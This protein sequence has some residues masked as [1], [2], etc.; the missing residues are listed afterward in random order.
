MKKPNTPPAPPTITVPAMPGAN[1]YAG[2]FNLSASPA[3]ILLAQVAAP[4]AAANMTDSHAVARAVALLYSCDEYL[5][6][7][8][9]AD[10]D[11]R[12]NQL[13]PRID[14]N[15]AVEILE[16]SRDTLR[17]YMNKILG[18]EK[19]ASAWKAA[20]NGEEIFDRELLKKLTAERDGAYKSRRKRT[21][22][23]GKI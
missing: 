10:L 23:S 14:L 21:E 4:F 17:A 8:E 6:K 20:L 19:A 22:K 1:N 13:C 3:A 11:W 7:M 2:A 12:Y 18:T 5:R 15:K 16:R 9:H